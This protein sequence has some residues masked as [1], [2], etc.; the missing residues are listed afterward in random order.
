MLNFSR[1]HTAVFSFRHK[2]KSLCGTI[3]LQRRRKGGSA[4]REI[5]MHI[6]AAWAHEVVTMVTA[7]SN[8]AAPRTINSA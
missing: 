4:D 8:Q 3:S 2:L 6:T 7:L 5:P 1:R